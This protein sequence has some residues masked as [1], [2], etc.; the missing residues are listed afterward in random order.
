MCGFGMVQFS[1]QTEFVRIDETIVGPMR[2][3]GQICDES[4]E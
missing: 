1:S 3:D 2:P 4:S